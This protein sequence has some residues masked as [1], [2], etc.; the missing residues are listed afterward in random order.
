MSFLK[1]FFLVS[2]FCSL[3][4]INAK[5]YTLPDGNTVPDIP[6]VITDNNYPYMIRLDAT[7][8]WVFY[9]TTDNFIVATS[10]NT[11][12]GY[13]NLSNYSSCYKASTSAKTSYD[14]DSKTYSYTI[15][16]SSW[17]SFSKV[18]SSNE[19]VSL[20]KWSCK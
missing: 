7:R 15:T 2:L 6:S 20:K 13:V 11:Y 10:D 9:C 4:I 1:K 8:V 5:A 12:T 17:S 16:G 14:D 18:V 3:F 19:F